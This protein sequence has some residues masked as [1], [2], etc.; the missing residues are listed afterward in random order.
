MVDTTVFYE[1][2]LET[3]QTCKGKVLQY[4]VTNGT[5]LAQDRKLKNSGLIELLDG[6]FISEVIG[7]E[8]PMVGFFEKVFETIGAYDKSEV[9]IVGDSL[10]SDMQGGNNVGIVTCWF[11]P[12]EKANSTD[13]RINYEIRDLQQVLDIL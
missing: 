9:L 4:A 1:N 5:K 10:T 2:G 7:V 13:L 11:N 6:V 3:V 12:D 8:K